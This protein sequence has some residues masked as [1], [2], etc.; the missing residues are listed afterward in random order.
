L[1][2]VIISFFRPAFIV[3]EATRG[4]RRKTIQPTAAAAAS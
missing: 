3:K 2:P 4:H 1:L